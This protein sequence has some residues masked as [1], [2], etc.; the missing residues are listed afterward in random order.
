MRL[1]FR[2]DDNRSRNFTDPLMLISF[3]ATSQPLGQWIL[4]YFLGEILCLSASDWVRLIQSGVLFLMGVLMIVI[5]YF[6]IRG[7]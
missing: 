4:R 7:K 6:Y 3:T 5:R 2:K 1:I